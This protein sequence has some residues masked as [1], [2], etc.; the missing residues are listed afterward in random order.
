MKINYLANWDDNYKLTWS[1]T[2]YSLL[3]A[4]KSYNSVTNVNMND[5]TNL[6]LA[7]LN[8][9]LYRM[10]HI[11]LFHFLIHK[12][13][14]KIALKQ[15]MSDSPN[16]QVHSIINLPNS[17]I[18]EDLTWDSLIWIKNTDPE[19]FQFSGF[20]NITDKSLKHFSNQQNRIIGDA[21]IV[22]SMSQWLAKFINEN[23]NRKA[24]YVGGGINTTISRTPI[25]SRDEQTFLFVGRDFQRKGG[26]L[27]VAAFEKVREL[28][29]ESRLKIAGPR[30][31]NLSINIKDIEGVDFLGDVSTEEIGKLMSTATFFV[32][33]SR[34]EA[35]GLVFVEAMANG[36]PIIAR[37]KFEMPYF[38]SQGSGI[39]MRSESSQKMEIENLFNCMIG[40]LE[41]RTEYLEEAFEAAPKIVNEYS[42]ESV[43]DRTISAI[44]STKKDS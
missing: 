31:E 9:K 41:N 33:P 35:Y 12:K 1:G 6:F 5:R 14:K 28:Y 8:S 36:M 17:Y 7:K 11:D 34:F 42:W 15:R 40:I 19:S 13:M 32:M 24:I 10:F 16:V 25:Q 23:T 37:D 2:T 26:D 3:M 30:L 43:A 4:L 27:V 44:K 22:L 39:L 21:N 20:Q 29:P 38:V 18:Y